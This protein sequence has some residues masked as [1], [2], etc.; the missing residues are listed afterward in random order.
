M[1]EALHDAVSFG[2]FGYPG[3][4]TRGYL[5]AVT[6]WQVKRF[7]WAVDPAWVVP[8]SGII[9]A[10]KTAIQAFTAPGNPS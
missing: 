7:G 1:I 6:G 10:V 8:T 5:D 9:T 2:I 4:P 3:G